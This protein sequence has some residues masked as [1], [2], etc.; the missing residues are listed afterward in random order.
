MIFIAF[1]GIVVFKTGLIRVVGL[2]ASQF[3]FAAFLDKPAK[4]QATQRVEDGLNP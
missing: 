3:L 1:N 2:V 4:L